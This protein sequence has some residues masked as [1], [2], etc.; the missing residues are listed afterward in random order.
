MRRVREQLET[1]VETPGDYDEV[2][3][4]LV[5]RILFSWIHAAK[6]E[7][8]RYVCDFNIGDSL[9][10]QPFPKPCDNTSEKTS[11]ASPTAPRT[12]ERPRGGAT[13]A[14]LH[15]TAEQAVECGFA[16]TVITWRREE[17]TAGICGHACARRG[18][19]RGVWQR[20]MCTGH[21][22][23]QVRSPTTSDDD[24]ASDDCA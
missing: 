19:H 24:A 17:T 5:G 15:P 16:C 22:A 13:P 10:A 6:K 1:A 20:C 21:L 12:S 18:G 9:A 7:A 14:A 8:R 11:S 2:W 3:H 4:R 23:T